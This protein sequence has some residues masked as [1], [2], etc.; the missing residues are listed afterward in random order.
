MKIKK[1]SRKKK[2]T[3]KMKLRISEKT[4]NQGRTKKSKKRKKNIWET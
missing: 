1:Y 2:N 3:G 4:K